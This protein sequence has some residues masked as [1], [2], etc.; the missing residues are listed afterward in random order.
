MQIVLSK[1]NKEVTDL[2]IGVVTRITIEI[3]HAF[4][5]MNFNNT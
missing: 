3:L 2:V 1:V 5:I 4:N